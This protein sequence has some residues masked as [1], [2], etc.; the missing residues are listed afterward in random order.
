MSFKKIIFFKSKI[1]LI[2]LIFCMLALGGI[3]FTFLRSVKLDKEHLSLL[4]SAKDVEILIS[5]SRIKLFD[6]SLSNDSLLR[7]EV[8]G[9]LSKACDIIASLNSNNGLHAGDVNKRFARNFGDVLRTIDK[10]IHHLE[11][12]INLSVQNKDSDN[13]QAIIA[14]YEAFHYTFHE[15]EEKLFDHISRQ[16]FHY[17]G[18][19]FTLILS[20]FAFLIICLV[21]LIRSVNT[22]IV[23]DRQNI[24]KSLEIENKERKRIAADLHDG[25]GSLLSSIGMYSKLLVKDLQDKQLKNK[26]DHLNQLSNMALENLENVINNLNPTTLE[27]YGLIKSLNIVCDNLNDIGNIYFQIESKNL[28]SELTKNVQLNLYRIS[29]ELIN[30]TLKHSGATEAKIII[31][32]K[33]KKIFYQYTDNGIGFDPIA[34][35]YIEGEKMG[36]HNMVSRVESLRGTY[37]IRS[38]QG[39]GI[40]IRIQIKI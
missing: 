19:V 13:T 31:K 16:N 39:N 14:E 29:N 37:S 38:E 30:N 35:Y 25:L 27:R 10:H 36:L 28:K 1:V 6:P 20:T 23:S 12:L 4:D 33:R 9:E 18:Q 11:H 17:R 3:I 7:V 32:T 15:F 24:D 8:F 40:D 5:H 2:V 22:Y 26:L 21:L 34:D